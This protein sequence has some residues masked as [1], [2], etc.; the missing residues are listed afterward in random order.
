MITE[1]HS[2]LVVE[3]DITFGKMLE[4]WFKK[5]G[6]NTAHVLKA[7]DAK[8]RMNDEPADVV[9]TDLRMPGEDGLSL[10]AWIKTNF[11]KTIVIMMTSYTDI[12]SAVS[13]IKM[14]AYD[15]IAKPFNPDQIFDK[16][17]DALKARDEKRESLQE[18]KAEE[19]LLQKRQKGYVEGSTEK[20]QSLYR[21]LGLVAP[22][23]FSVLIKGESGVG[24]EHIARM[25]HDN[26]KVAKGPFVAV[27]CGVLSKD[28]AASDL[29][30]HVK[31]AFT[32]ALTDKTGYFVRAD[33]GTLFLDEIGNLSIEVQ[34]Q[35]LRS[36]QERK[37]SPVGSEKEIKVNVRVIAATNED[38]SFAA[39]HGYFRTDLFH[40]ISEFV[41]EV[42]SLRE[43]RDDIPL[44][45][46]HFLKKARLSL[47]KR[48]DGFEPEAMEILVN[49][50]WPGNVRELKNI[51]NRLV[52]LETGRMIS[53]ATIPDHFK[54][55]KTETVP[56]KLKLADEQ[57]RIE[58]ALR[59]SGYNILRS[60]AL[61][62]MDTKV[63]YEKI[64]IYNID[65][66]PQSE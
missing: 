52:L 21:H 27:D 40:R 37:V 11:P 13:A 7:S 42:P 53:A 35:L 29:F 65:Y 32:G 60:A 46:N 28:L 5:K 14:G 25:I 50:D 61:L 64:K 55:K 48:V 66:A 57:Q 51:V 45:L 34:T 3:D 44:F 4:A 6:L 2:I 17:G 54:V 18:E 38:I 56:E 62:N 39:D 20:Y 1:E 10:T 8:K 23:D 58:D 22:T 49:Y 24:K 47:K 63:L 36:L 43:S 9:I 12:Q 31:G 41:L 33:G 30:G 59:L 16:I 19:E 15:Y 26:S